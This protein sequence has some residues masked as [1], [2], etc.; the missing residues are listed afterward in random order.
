LWGQTLSPVAV[1]VGGAKWLN[2]RLDGNA[3]YVD[4][5]H[6]NELAG[7]TPIGRAGVAPAPITA[8]ALDERDVYR[9]YDSFRKPRG[10]P[11]KFGANP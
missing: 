5:Q 2:R 7:V 4:E 1:I 10:A 9:N 8:Q 3:I 6:A 11:E